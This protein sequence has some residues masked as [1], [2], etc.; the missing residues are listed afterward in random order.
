MTF[1]LQT[2]VLHQYGIYL[3]KMIFQSIHKW[4]NTLASMNN[5]EYYHYMSVCDLDHW[6]MYISWSSLF[7]IRM[8]CNR[9]GHI[10]A[11]LNIDLFC[12]IVLKIEIY[13]LK[14]YKTKIYLGFLLLSCKENI[15]WHFGNSHL[16]WDVNNL[17]HIYNV[18]N[19]YKYGFVLNIYISGM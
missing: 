13:V 12:K 3:I 6:A 18:G 9:T 11:Y 4:Q 15:V 1:E 5:Y 7:V 16:I 8:L 17:T 2:W 14:K 10:T 19:I